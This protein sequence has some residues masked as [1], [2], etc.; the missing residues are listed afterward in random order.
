MKFGGGSGMIRRP[1]REG[2]SHRIC[3][4]NFQ[5]DIAT[6]VASVRITPSATK[7][8]DWQVKFERTALKPQGKNSR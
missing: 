2:H 6:P 5:T 8:V 4:Q 1:E 3:P 7:V